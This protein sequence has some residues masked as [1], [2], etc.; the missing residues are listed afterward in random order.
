MFKAFIFDLDGT[1]FRGQKVID[2]APEALEEIRANGIK[3]FYMTNSA[4]KSRSELVEK[5]NKMGFDVKMNEIYCSAYLAARYLAKNHKGK[6][7]YVIGENGLLKEL[8]NHQIKS[9]D[10]GQV[11]IVGLDRKLNYEKLAKA[12]IN[13]DNG[14]VFL[15]TN[16]DA[17][18]PV[19]KGSMPGCGAIVAALECSSGKKA[20]ILGKPNTY[21]MEL[22][23]Q[24]QKLMK[25]DILMV[26]DRLDTDIL[27]AKNCEVKSALV[28]SG[29]AKRSDVSAIK[30]DYIFDSVVELSKNIKS[31]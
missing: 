9:Q 26:G 5:L 22:I 13:L 10:D 23:E 28:L 14:A 16:N 25:K 3:T 29:N 17:T 12:H 20:Y 1:L 2:G 19:E 11:V 30:P 8:E 24:E 18:Y 27:F 15:A 7:I 21:F 6:K 31:E 4:T